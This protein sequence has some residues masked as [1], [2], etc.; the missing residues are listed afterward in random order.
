MSDPNLTMQ[1]QIQALQDQ[2]EP[3]RKSDVPPIFLPYTQRALNS[4]AATTTLGDF[5]QPWEV[6]LLVFSVTVFVVATNNGT[7]FW[8]VDLLDTTGATIATVTTSSG[9]TASTWTRLS[10]TTVTQPL[11][12]NAALSV[13]ATKTLSPGALFAVPSVSVL[14]IGN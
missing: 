5:A 2:L 1:R 12:S 13:I 8:T 10:D 14:R 11:S 4:V 7:N 9:V 6:Y 3:L